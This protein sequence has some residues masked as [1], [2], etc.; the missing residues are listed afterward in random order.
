MKK[1]VL[2]LYLSE[3]YAQS[4]L[5]EP[6]GG[7]WLLHATEEWPSKLFAYAGDDT[8]G[9]DEF[10][11]HLS[12]FLSQKP[13]TIHTAAVALDT[14]L[15]FVNTIPVDDPSAT[16][17]IKAQIDWELNEYFPGSPKGVFI[18]DYEVMAR[19]DSRPYADVLAVSVRREFVQKIHRAVNR[20]TLQLGPVDGDLFA[21]GT[22]MR[23]N[24][25][26]MT[27]KRVALAGVKHERLDVSV[28]HHGEI[29]S[30]AYRLISTDEDIVRELAACIKRSDPPDL[31]IL[32]GERVDEEL[33]AELRGALTVPVDVLNPFRV[34]SVDTTLRL[35]H[36][37]TLRPFRYAAAVGIALRQK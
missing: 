20:L 12:F 14:G 35:K 21:A 8:P 18:S 33:L 24:H 25:P 10:V 19:P 28:L 27:R 22:A 34:V 5:L 17:D 6:Q 9:M 16:D 31:A 36:D 11:E 30:F 4:L 37:P 32:F 26:E 1:A 2:A 29:E 7:R 3:H 15:L 13:F 23:A